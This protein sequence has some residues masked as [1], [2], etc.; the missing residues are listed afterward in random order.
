M[1]PYSVHPS[2]QESQQFRTRLFQVYNTVRGMI[3][4]KAF[5]RALLELLVAH[6][7][8]RRRGI[9]LNETLELL[10]QELDIN[11]LLLQAEHE[12]LKSEL[13]EL[14]GQLG[15]NGQS[16]EAYLDIIR[17]LDLG[18]PIIERGTGFYTPPDWLI[19]FFVSLTNPN[20]PLFFLDWAGSTLIPY[21]LLN[22]IKSQP[23]KFEFVTVDQAPY[24]VDKGLIISPVENLR[25]MTS[26]V[27][28]NLQ[29]IRASVQSFETW[30]TA[31]D[32]SQ[33]PVPGQFGT[34]L[35]NLYSPLYRTARNIEILSQSLLISP[36]NLTPN[37]RTIIFGPNT[38]L[39]GQRWRKFRDQVQASLHVEAILDF[40]LL[41]RF[42]DPLVP[43]VILLSQPQQSITQRVTA[44]AP[45]YLNQTISNPS[46]LISD[47][48]TYLGIDE[49]DQAQSDLTNEPET[50]EQLTKTGTIRVKVRSFFEH[51]IT[52][53]GDRWDP[54]F[55]CPARLY[56]QDVLIDS[57][58]ANWL[59]EVAELIARG[60]PPATLKP[61]IRTSVAGVTFEGRQ[62]LIGQVIPGD[63]VLL[64]REEDNPY[65]SNAVRVERRSGVV[66]GYL[67]A[68]LAAEVAATISELGG[69]HKASVIRVQGGTPDLPN[70]G[71]TIQFAPPEYTNIGIEVIFIRPG[72]I[73]NNRLTGQGELAWLLNE[74]LSKAT[75]VQA[76][77][78]LIY[79]RG[80]GRACVVPREFDGAVCHHEL[81][82]IRPGTSIDPLY[83]L[84]FILSSEFQAQLQFVARNGSIS[85]VDLTD[86]AE[87]L[88]IVPPLEIQ[89]R[90]ALV[91]A[92]S[93]G[94]LGPGFKDNI[95]RWL[96]LSRSEETIERQWIPSSLL[97]NLFSDWD[98]LHSLEDWLR[99]K[100]DYIHQLQN[101]VA[102]GQFS[103]NKMGL[104]TAI[105][106][107]GL[108]TSILE[109]T[110]HSSDKLVRVKPR[111]EQALTD[112]QTA[113]GQVLDPFLHHRLLRLGELLDGLLQI[114]ALLLPVQFS[115]EQTIL[116]IGIPSLLRVLARNEGDVALQNFQVSLKLSQGEFVEMPSWQLSQLDPGETHPFEARLQLDSLGIVEIEC[117]ISCTRNNNPV[118]QTLLLLI[119]AVPAEQ[120]PF[121]LIQPNPYI[122]GG[123]VHDP[124]M[125]FGRQDVLN[126]LSANLIGKHQTNVII[127][128]GNRRT[129]KS[130]ILQQII[131]S[132]L[133]APHIPV[134][135][136]CQGLGS[137]LDDQ[138]FFFKFAREIWKAIR[139]Q[140]GVEVS[141][142][143]QR[144]DISRDDA[145]YDF[146]EIL[147]GWSTVIPGR[148]LILLIDEFEVIDMAIRQEELGQLVLE[149]LRHLFQHQRNV[150]AVLTGS[151]RLS[152]LSQD[153][154]SALFG[155]GLKR[156]IGF[157]EETAARELITQPLAGII[158]YAP[159]AVDRI[160]ELTACQPYFVQVLCHNI[161][162]ILNT[163]RTSYV[164]Q[165]YVE[166]A[167]QETLTSADGHVSSMFNSVDPV[168]FKAVLVYLASSLAQP[169]TLPLY[170][171]EQFAESNHLPISRI[172][173]ET[174][175]RELTNR[176]LI[177]MEGSPE[178]RLYGFKIDLVRQ[179]IRRNYDLRSAIALA[180]S[181]SYIRED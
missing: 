95:E 47:L 18:D 108:L 141:P 111:L 3:G 17:V 1:M 115:L 8:Q 165:G 61:Y 170:Q 24:L 150:A 21:F 105:I 168:A 113:A 103:F 181:T 130:S 179:W 176:D 83:L 117:V 125:F 16:P 50:P 143:I 77:D 34:A 68:K 89:R 32:Q 46:D 142:P 151:Y 2:K 57:S 162:N 148:R 5:Q 30:S 158:T 114:E 11:C 70:R 12:N 58:Q 173:L 164:T 25:L 71:I 75:R 7:L 82:I 171:I 15:L 39:D 9:D 45:T 6:F 91:F 69:S 56:L 66:L 44:L 149:N 23:Q 156:E 106:A 13:G 172:E 81:A 62:E 159:T 19:K 79:L 40:S 139:N 73:T 132:N 67:P 76:G 110:W 98:R 177:R 123:P 64:R 59:G 4:L 10:A 163:Y 43:T 167:A 154:W 145:F 78:I 84:A 94:E 136:D 118:E 128:Q 31:N 175:L 137:K 112:F 134:Y 155:L 147:E 122:T 161:V 20:Q 86:L 48:L 126:F 138:S 178:Q 102:H 116:P 63:T 26:L 27:V 96:D 100:R 74:H 29:Q 41:E 65:D 174:T 97:N 140:D 157:L 133:F 120:V 124:S 14:I 85:S 49:T 22:W 129:G 53:L 36:R 152:Q 87:L 104:D 80:Q 107:L 101:L 160:I 37:G 90:I 166:E 55:Y 144:S 153:Y 180:Q 93:Q 28:E 42:T 131:K 72:D 92:E 33:L 60:T 54:K 38:L 88:V 119:E 127:L 51:P 146:K 121:A 35:L 135:I 99:L 109:K 169:D 52:E